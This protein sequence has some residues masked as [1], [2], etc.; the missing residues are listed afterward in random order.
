MLARAVASQPDLLLVDEPT[1]QLDRVM[2]ASV[3]TALAGLAATRAIVVIAT[4]D[5]SV[6]ATAAQVIPLDGA[7]PAPSGSLTAGPP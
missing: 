4:H 5:P 7:R 1:A 3:T 2:A 6:T